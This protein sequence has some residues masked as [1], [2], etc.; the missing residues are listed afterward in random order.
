[1]MK[2]LIRRHGE[3]SGRDGLALPFPTLVCGVCVTSWLVRS[4]RF[5]A[6]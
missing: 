1:M 5:G 4:E 3:A 2:T 6:Y